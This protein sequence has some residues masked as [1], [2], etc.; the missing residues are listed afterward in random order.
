MEAH[1]EIPLEWLADK[2]GSHYPFAGVPANA[3]LK[4][5]W[6][7]PQAPQTH[8]LGATSSVVGVAS[9]YEEHQFMEVGGKLVYF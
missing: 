2:G 3:G 5:N 8:V 7:M 9:C 4:I 1:M 6:F